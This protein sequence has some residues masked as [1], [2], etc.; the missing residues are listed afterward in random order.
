M[1]KTEQIA[2]LLDFDGTL[3]PIA[4]RPDLPL[5]AASPRKILKGLSQGAGVVVGI[6]SGRNLRDLRRRVGLQ[7]IYYAGNHGLEL[8]GPGLRFIHPGAAAARPV[9]LRI[10]E[11]LGERLCG[12]AGVLVENKRF[13]LSLH[14]RQLPPSR[15]SQVQGLFT[16]TVRPYLK[17]GEIRVTRG[18]L[19][20]EVRPAVDWDKGRAVH[21]IREQVERGRP[22]HKLFLC[23]LGD[24]ETD[25][26]A[27]RALAEDDVAVFVGK[28][29]RAS[30]ASYY[31]RDPREVE[32]FL[33]RLR[34]LRA[35]TAA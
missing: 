10:A 31:L 2:L 9:L 17:W 1:Q 4:S 6:I 30:A 3:T 21:L 12:V 34:R 25:E 16:R 29:K 18:K 20:L 23:Y 22:P 15:R 28:P 11:E 13:S 24:D 14:L 32:D 27:F 35:S 33:T 19:V 26:A 5:L 8:Q 7:G